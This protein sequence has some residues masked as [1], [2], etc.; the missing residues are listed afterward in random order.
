VDHK[1][2]A[3]ELFGKERYQDQKGVVVATQ[4]WGIYGN[5]TPRNQQRMNPFHLDSIERTYAKMVDV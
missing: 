3:S 4:N 5:T 1:G 2:K